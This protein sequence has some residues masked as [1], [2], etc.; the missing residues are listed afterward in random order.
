MSREL[1]ADVDRRF[2]SQLLPADA[3]LDAADAAA[4]DAVRA[5]DGSLAGAT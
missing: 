4:T 3:G 1:W 2:E 5:S